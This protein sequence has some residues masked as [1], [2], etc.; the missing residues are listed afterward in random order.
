M[1]VILMMRLI[2]MANILKSIVVDL[3]YIFSDLILLAEVFPEVM[4]LP[5]EHF[6]HFH[7]F[8][9]YSLQLVNV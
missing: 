6:V 9:Y 7:L 2:D 4:N 5:A 8:L 3:L 1:L